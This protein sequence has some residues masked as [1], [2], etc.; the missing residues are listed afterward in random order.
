MDPSQLPDAGVQLRLTVVYTFF[1]ALLA[2]P[3]SWFAASEFY[4]VVLVGSDPG[5]VVQYLAGFAWLEAVSIVLLTTLLVLADLRKR[6]ESRLY[7]SRLEER[8]G[9]IGLPRRRGID[10]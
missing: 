4:D 1:A 6:S 7:S 8:E 2:A 5:V 10:R 9:K 3:L